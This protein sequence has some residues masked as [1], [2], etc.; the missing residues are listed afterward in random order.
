MAPK[1]TKKVS[2]AG[3]EDKRS[4]TAKFTVSLAGDFLGMQLIY[5]GKTK[6]SLPPVKF[7]E[8]FS[9]SANQKAYSNEEESIKVINEVVIPY[10][11]AKKEELNLPT[12]QP[13]LL[14]FDVFRGQMTDR[15]LNLLKVNNIFIVK[16]PSNMTHIFQP[17]DLSTNGWAKTF[18]KNKFS[19]WYAEKIQM[20]LNYGV[21]LEEISIKFLLSTLKPLHATWLIELYNELSS[22][23]G[24]DVIISG[25]RQSGIIDALELGSASLPTLDPFF[26][27]DGGVDFDANVNDIYGSINPQSCENYRTIYVNKK[28]KIEND[29]S[30]DS[31][32]TEADTI[33]LDEE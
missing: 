19:L 5:G 18:M 14:I 8:N 6:R 27:I 12:N 1:G 17:L 10:L 13:S 4:I 11:C 32:G 20:H 15:V 26:Y 23:A 30:S 7:P 22:E 24:R 2:I 29:D 21:P 31:S 25:W 3:S 28:G 33:V 9:L 16:V